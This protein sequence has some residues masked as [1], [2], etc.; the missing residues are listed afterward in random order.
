MPLLSVHAGLESPAGLAE[1]L[2]LAEAEDL[3]RGDLVHPGCTRVRLPQR[4]WIVV[5][6][7]VAHREAPTAAVLRQVSIRHAPEPRFVGN[8]HRI[9]F[10]RHVEALVERIAPSRKNTVRVTHQVFCLTFVQAS[11]EVQRAVQPYGQQRRNG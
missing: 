1:L 4:S 8:P 5:E 11:A 7:A 6:G 2:A 3:L 9:T 10:D